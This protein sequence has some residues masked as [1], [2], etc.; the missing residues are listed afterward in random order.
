VIP[1]SGMVVGKGTVSRRIRGDFDKPFSEISRP[2]IAWNITRRCNLNCRHCYIDAR[3][4]A[5]DMDGEEAL[6]IVEQIH[7]VGSPLVILSGG[8][9]LLRGDLF[10]IIEEL[11]S[12]GIK[13]ALSTNGTLI[14]DEVAK[15]IR[16][17]EVDYVG[18]SLDSPYPEWHDMFRGTPGCFNLT[19]E[20]VRRLLKEGVPVGLRFTV[21]R[22]NVDQVPKY[23]ELALKL[24]IGRVVLYHLSAAGRARELKDWLPT[25][26][27]YF[28]LM[29]YLVCI[30]RKYGEVLEVETAMAP[31][32]GI[33]VA[34]VLAR[35]GEEF[36][37]MLQ[38]VKMRGSCGRKIV[39]I[40]P[41]GTV[42]PCQFVDF[43][44][45]GNVKS[46]RLRDMLNINRRE[47]AVFAEP[48]KFIKFG[49]CAGCPFVEYC[50]GGDRVRAYYMGG[51]LEGSDPYCYLNVKGLEAMFGL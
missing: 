35:D 36:R 21:T 41:D 45:L 4:G 32:D 13:V 16:K 17:A 26:D 37:R 6:S 3:P 44:S 9:P 12:K 27:Q 19:I 50:G 8:E 34:S 46:E 10:E 18:V 48:H 42:R 2:I 38:L 22:Y 23:F 7:E 5:E 15:M 39:S 28:R 14:T 31:F 51:G 11:K 29:D 43:V 47:F 33:Y 30:S 20:G 1:I 49:K 40:Y 25:E 24:G